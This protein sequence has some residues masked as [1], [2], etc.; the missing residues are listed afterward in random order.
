MFFKNKVDRAFKLEEKN[1]AMD[2]GRKD[3]DPDIEIEED[4]TLEKGL[5]SNHYLGA[6]SFW[7]NPIS[8]PYRNF[9]FL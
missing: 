6:F 2:G 1:R 7:S 9:T 4:I 3:L 5:F 8:S